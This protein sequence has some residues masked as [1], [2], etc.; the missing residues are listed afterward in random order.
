MKNKSKVRLTNDQ[1]KELF[2]YTERMHI[3]YKD[4]QFEIVD[5]MASGVEDTMAANNKLTFSKAL[6]NYAGTLPMRFFNDLIEEKEKALTQFWNRTFGKYMLGFLNIPRAIAFVILFLAFKA[7]TPYLN[8]GAFNII[9]I[10]IVFI[11]FECIWLYKNQFIVNLDNS[12][13]VLKTFKNAILS[14]ACG[15]FL[16]PL[17]IVVLEYDKLIIQPWGPWVIAFALT[18]I[19]LFSYSARYVFPKMLKAEIETKYAHHNINLA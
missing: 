14:A 7:V 12:Y 18:S 13:L 3:K 11:L 2:A 5:H 15:L 1:I 9:Y 19:T 10:T 6:Y 16:F 4:V 17:Y 8:F